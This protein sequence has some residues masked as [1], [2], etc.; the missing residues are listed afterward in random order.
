METKYYTPKIEE[1]YIG[2]RFEF[3]RTLTTYIEGQEP[4]VS[5]DWLEAVVST[6][7]PNITI[8]MIDAMLVEGNVR[9][10]VLDEADIIEAGWKEKAIS[11]NGGFWNL[12][13][14]SLHLNFKNQIVRIIKNIDGYNYVCFIGTIRNY[15]ELLKVMEM[16][17]IKAE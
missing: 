2:F 17:D 14:Y 1:F 13:K 8:P 12:G 9:V 5:N 3:Y 10:K 11:G 16:L 6:D 15:N 4:I 7:F